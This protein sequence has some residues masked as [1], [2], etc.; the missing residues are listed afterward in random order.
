M[1][2]FVAIML[3][4]GQTF[5]QQAE[6]VALKLFVTL[7]MLC[8]IPTPAQDIPKS[9]ALTDKSNISVT[10]ILKSLRK[11]CPNVSI[12]SDATKSDYT[13]E[14]IETSTREGIRIV[15]QRAFDLTLFD[16]DGITV[17]S[18]STDSLASSVNV[19]C[20]A[21]KISVP[22]EV[23][24]TQNLTQSSDTRDEWNGLVGTI[25]N[26]T[27]G[28]RTHTDASTISIIVNGEHALLDCYERRIGCTTIG[29]G[30][31]YGE[32]EG[33][34]IWVSFRMPVTHKPVRNHYKIA[35]SW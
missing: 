11:E 22:I 29:P 18:A 4:D 3:Q 13:L 15:V 7:V 14:A 6:G 33:N 8:A 27:T 32:R 34:G 25:V 26:S 24:D 23:V 10:H 1:L 16:R 21:I 19:L 12:G 17:S 5:A 30:K 35:G 31:Y 9:I 20:H 2:R 28:R